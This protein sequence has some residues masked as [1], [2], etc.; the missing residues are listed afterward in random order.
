ML[1]DFA[2]RLKFERKRLD[3]TQQKLGSLINVSEA[4]IKR[5][6]GGTPI[7]SDKLL[8]MSEHGLD[9]VFI[10]TGNRIGLSNAQNDEIFEDEFCLI[11]AYDVHASAGDGSLVSNTMRPK[12]R[13][14][15]RKDW[16]KLHGLKEKDL[17]VIYAKGDSMEPTISNNN[18]LLVDTSDKNMDE[19]FIYVMRNGDMLWVKRIQWVGGCELLLISD[20][21]AYKPIPFT[22]DA[23]SEIEVIG[24]VVNL[25][26]EF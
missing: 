25:S 7:P 17:C 18:A 24:R 8:Q 22:F 12:S 13:M 11:P 4:T 9:S 5:W 20:N 10:L 26:K 6:E 16:M 2:D 23:G 1:N 3:L 21:D 14:A 15:F 19:G